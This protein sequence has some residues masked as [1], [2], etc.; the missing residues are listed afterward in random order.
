VAK[1]LLINS[2][3][4]S[5]PRAAVVVDG[6]VEELLRGPGTGGANS[7][8]VCRGRVVNLEP[9]VGAAFVDI[10]AGRNAFLHV[11]DLPGVGGEGEERARIEDHFSVGD[12][13]VAQ[14]TR[15]PVDAKGAVLTANIALPGRYLVLMPGASSSGVSRRIGDAD[16]RA[17]LRELSRELVERAGHGVILR[18]AAADAAPDSIAADLDRLVE[19]WRAIEAVAHE[20]PPRTLL[21]DSD[22]ATRASRELVGPDVERVVVDTEQARANASSALETFDLDRRVPVELHDDSRPLFHAFGI[23]QQIDESCARSVPLPGG[24]HVVFDRTEAL[25]AIDVNSGKTRSSGYLEETARRTN[26]EAATVIAH[27]LRLRDEGGLVV[28]DFIDM[29]DEAN[30][31]ALEQGFRVALRRD[32]ARIRIGGL[33]PFGLFTLTRQRRAP[34]TESSTRAQ[35]GAARALREF[36]DRHAADAKIR[37]AI[38]AHPETA[39]VLEGMVGGAGGPVVV[40]DPAL[41]PGQWALALP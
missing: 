36:R 30:N 38:R 37:L 19:Q 26:D 13:I 3:I 21:T 32:R 29:R 31:S 11:S 27:Q 4:P 6:R 39:L 40:P 28:V 15:A 14:V 41:G 1:L 9:S 33:G 2:A 22:F 23:E 24:G 18:T 17:R 5:D 7:G 16:S 34:H 8:D 20:G 25:L 10:G 35:R 12:W